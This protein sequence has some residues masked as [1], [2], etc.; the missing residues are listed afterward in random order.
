MPS[1]IIIFGAGLAGHRAIQ[2]YRTQAGID[3]VAV[4]DND[5]AKQGGD[6]SG[7][8][9][10]APESIASIAY[11]RIIIASDFHREIR[12]Q[13]IEKLGVP[14]DRIDLA[15]MLIVKGGVDLSSDARRD[16][17]RELLLSSSAYLSE[18]GV[19]HIVD[20][21]TL[22]GLHRD[23]DLLPWDNDI[24]MAIHADRLEETR[25]ALGR[26]AAS[27]RAPGCPETPWRV[28]LVDGTIDFG[29]RSA[30]LPRIFKVEPAED[31]ELCRHLQLDVIIKHPGEGLVH[32]LVGRTTL[33][34]AESFMTDLACLQFRGIAL[35]HP[36][37]LDGYLTTL[38]GD[39]RTP[40]K[41]WTHTQ[42]ANIT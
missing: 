41:T 27:F 20:H 30:V 38:Y 36:R 19:A 34:A 9:I 24:D 22:L 15:P 10:I 42:Y 14:A 21:G 28:R 39:W 31:H 8:R 37:D 11:D 26:F 29:G 12:Q 5:K 18:A 7:I 40:R 23:G 2:H 1:S 16:L 4:T 13:L 3:L 17:A 32:W 35:P 33:H 25:A 6:I